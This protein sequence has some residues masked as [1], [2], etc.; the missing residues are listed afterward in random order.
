M[1][2]GGAQCSRA[3]QRPAVGSTPCNVAAQ[4]L[5][6]ALKFKLRSK[7]CAQDCKP[8]AGSGVRAACR[9]APSKSPRCQGPVWPAWQCIAV[10]NNA[11]HP[12]SLTAE[13]SLFVPSS[14][15]VRAVCNIPHQIP[16]PGGP[17]HWHMHAC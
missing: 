1:K 4:P 10:I 9:C 17:R 16:P 12:L 15:E 2:T 13:G 3:D 11:S 7:Q 5:G 14:I 6:P 8:C